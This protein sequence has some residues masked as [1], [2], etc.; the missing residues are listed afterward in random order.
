MRR[1][2]VAGAA[3]P[4][5]S[6]SRSGAG[7]HLADYLAAEQLDAVY[8][9]PLRRAVETGDA[10]R[11]SHG[12]DGRRRRRRR[13]GPH[14]AASTS[15]S[16]SSRRR[17]TRAGRRSSTASGP[18]DETPGR[19]PR[20]GRSPRSSRSSTPHPGGR[21][22]VVCH[23]GVINGYLAAVLGLDPTRPA[24][25]T[26]TT[27][28]STASLAASTGRALDPD[29]QRDLAPAR[30]RAAHRPASRLVDDARTALAR[31]PHRLPRRLAV[32]VPRRRAAR[33]RLEAA[34][35]DR[36]DERDAVG[37]RAAPRLRRS[38]RRAGRLAR[39][40][41]V[42]RP[43]RP[44]RI[45]GA[46]TD[47]PCLRVKP[48]SRHR[49]ARAGG[50]S[51]SRSTAACSS[52]RGSTA[53]SASPAGS[54]IA[55][56]SARLVDVDEPIARVPQLAIH[57]DRDV[58]E[59][60]LMLDK[61]QHLT[62]GVGHRHARRAASSPSGS[63]SRPAIDARRRGGSCACSTA[64][65]GGAR[66]RPSR[67]SPAAGSTTRCRAGRRRGAGRVDRP[68]TTVPVI[69][70][71]DHEEVGSASTTGAAGPLL[72]HVLER[73]VLATRRRTRRLPPRAGRLDAA[74]RP[75]TP[76]PCTPTTPSATSPT[77]GRSSTHGP[78]I[79]INSNQR[80]ATSADD[81]GA[82]P[83][84]VRRRP[85]CRGRCSCRATTCRAA[86]RSARSP[87]PASAS[88]PSTSACRSCRCTRP[89][90]CAASHDPAVAG[91]GARAPTSTASDV[92]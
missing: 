60:G 34:G 22:A 6:R 9:S 39:C 17:T 55:D 83:A 18:S 25:S 85:A 1:E 31:R 20:P 66:R 8:A 65:G 56:G 61:Q 88:P 52:T 84:G 30:H 87:R 28:R 11:R 75:T 5:L 69:A 48:R 38:R 91:V 80:Y 86:R 54:C 7:R 47:S 63:P 59:R 37:R 57:L 82:V 51:A 58:N 72:E 46:H 3:D 24:S 19:V 64:A 50:S 70:L 81:G 78:A 16:R 53:T 13:V 79:K 15:R 4:E 76:T 12:L 2:L 27:R 73:L 62:P 90:S 23:G 29:D 10:G 77:T 26:R 74:C 41:A 33:R 35:F 44:F 42:D 71:F 89:A 49:R 43:D 68:P 21:I 32:A 67:C 92:A 40:R 14:V 36:V 45:V